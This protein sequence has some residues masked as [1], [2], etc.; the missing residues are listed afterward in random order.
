MKLYILN[1]NDNIPNFSKVKTI[2]GKVYVFGNATREKKICCKNQS[3]IVFW[4]LKL[5]KKY[6]KNFNKKLKKLI[7]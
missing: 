6:M 3:G 1:S 2:D 5:V 7:S 4:I